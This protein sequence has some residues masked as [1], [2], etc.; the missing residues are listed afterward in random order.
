MAHRIGYF[1]VESFGKDHNTKYA[2]FQNRA[3]ADEY[4][5]QFDDTMTVTVRRT[6]LEDAFV[7]M[8]GN[9]IGDNGFMLK[10]P[11]TNPKEAM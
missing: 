2:Y 11:S 8:T 3:D 1:T 5:K 7:E 6:N 9:R 4:A 10:K